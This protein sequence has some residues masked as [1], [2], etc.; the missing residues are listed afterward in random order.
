LSFRLF[1]Y[2]CALCGGWAA[3]L[4]WVLGRLVALGDSVG[5]TGLKGMFLGMAIAL[6][7]GLVDALWAY[8]LR[9]FWLVIPRVVICGAIGTLGGVVGGVIGQLL[10]DWQGLDALLLVGWMLT[11]LMVGLS[12]GSYDWL[13]AWVREEELGWAGKKVLRGVIGGAV[14]GLLGGLLDLKMGAVWAGVFPDKDGLWSPTLTGFIAL[15]LCIG[16][17]IGLA[18]V[19]LKEAWLKV[20]AG[21]RKGREVL[22]NRPSLTIG[23]AETCDL[24]LFGDMMIEKLHARIYQQDGKHLIADNKSVHG[25]FVNDQR[26][27]EPTLLRDGD[28]I[29]VGNAYLRFHERRKK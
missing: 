3:A 2:W 16:L 21:F 9:Q 7:L 18:Q 11:G 1:V 6:A 12:I 4:G 29:R 17:L 23:R 25:T 26:I 27:F 14:G 22:L 10:F 8:S 24:G 13:R 19:V 15:G 5:S 28:L 20:E